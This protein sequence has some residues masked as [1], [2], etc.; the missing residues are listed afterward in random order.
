MIAVSKDVRYGSCFVR[1]TSNPSL[2]RPIE[3][4][5]PELVSTVRGGGFPIRGCAVTVFG[6]IPPNWEKSTNACISR[7]YPKVPEAT[8]IGFL[9]ASRFSWTARPTSVEASLA[10]VVASD[11]M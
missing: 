8:K 9:K 2:S 10:E 6:T 3:F 1:N 11:G 5:S 4:S 7:A